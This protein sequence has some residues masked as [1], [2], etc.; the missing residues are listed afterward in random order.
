MIRSNR[1]R[2]RMLR[3]ILVWMGIVLLGIFWLA[4]R[5]NGDPVSL[6]V[7][8]EVPRAGEPIIATFKISN[9]SSES[10]VTSYQ[11]Y[12][13]GELLKEGSAT[14][15]A[16][17][18][19]TYRYAY[20]NLLD[21]GERL[22]FVLKTQSEQGNYE[23]VLSTPP[24][25]P[26]V[27]SSFVSFASF[28]TS[29]MSTS[30]SSMSSMSYYQATFGTDLL[31][32]IGLLFTIVLITLLVFLELT[33]PLVKNKNLLVLGRLRLRF[34]TVTWILFIIFIGMLYTKVVMILNG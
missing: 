12:A 16:G 22:N 15:A 25:P 23:K 31:L 14:I 21:I 29:V 3:L 5:G 11:F 10:L 9:P 33:M 2:A 18:G 17:S 24:Y 4:A 20:G 32:N 7:V 19:K 26:Q 34:N 30:M 8:P 6:M 28:S 1:D 13:N 27:W